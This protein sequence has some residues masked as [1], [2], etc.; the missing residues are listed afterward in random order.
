M[1]TEWY[2]KGIILKFV[3]YFFYN[4][5]LLFPQKSDANSIIILI[6]SVVR[7]RPVTANHCKI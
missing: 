3:I 4:F 1:K 5:N 6:D 7:N 2:K